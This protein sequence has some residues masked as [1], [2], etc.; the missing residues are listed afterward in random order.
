VFAFAL[1]LQ[2]P[3]W[4]AAQPLVGTIADKRSG[5]R[6]LAVGGVVYARLRTRS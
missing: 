4:G 2:N 5:G 3:I 6:T 1:A